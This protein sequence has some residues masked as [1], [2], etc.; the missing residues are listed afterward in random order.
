[1]PPVACSL[2]RRGRHI[3][4]AKCTSSL[5]GLVILTLSIVFS[6]SATLR[7]LRGTGL[8]QRSAALLG[9]DAELIELYR[10]RQPTISKHQQPIAGSTVANRR[11]VIHTLA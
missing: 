1:M 9:L 8:L 10:K 3:G 5:I 2:G 7:A 4:W 6:F 11:K